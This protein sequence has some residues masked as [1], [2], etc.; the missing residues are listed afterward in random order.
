MDLSLMK[1]E[2]CLGSN[3]M[4]EARGLSGVSLRLAAILVPRRVE[5]DFWLLWELPPD[6]AAAT[7]PLHSLGEAQERLFLAMIANFFDMMV[8]ADVEVV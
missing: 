7:E 6:A 8:M 2:I 4:A 5:L 3:S 1:I